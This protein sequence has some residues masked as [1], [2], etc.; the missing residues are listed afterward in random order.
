MENIYPY[1]YQYLLVNKI[2]LLPNIGTF[3][4]SSVGARYDYP[5]QQMQP[6]KSDFTF[7]V[8]SNQKK[9]DHNLYEYLK[10]ALHLESSEAAEEIFDNYTAEISSQLENHANV[11]LPGL[12]VLI[13]RS[14]TLAFDN[15]FEPQSFYPNLNVLPISKNGETTTIKSGDA[16]FSRKEME[17]ML[18]KKRK[19]I[20][21]WIYVLLTLGTLVIA[22]GV[23]YYYIKMNR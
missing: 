13:Y 18:E 8:Q 6:P 23:Y 21:W 20:A 14:R 16:E 10:K 9:K 19:G 7:Q 17:A 5:T 15:S 1:L 4:L 12:G 22:A 2:L 11:E 3:S